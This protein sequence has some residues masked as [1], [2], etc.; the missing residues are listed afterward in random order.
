MNQEFCKDVDVALKRIATHIRK[1]PVEFSHSM[2]NSSGSK[3][4]LKLENFQITGSFKARGAVNKMSLMAEEN[5]EKIITH[6]MV[7]PTWGRSFLPTPSPTKDSAACA[8][9]SKANDNKY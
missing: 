1:T 3:V 4:L 8:K 7:S 9:P 5:P 6:L 2:S